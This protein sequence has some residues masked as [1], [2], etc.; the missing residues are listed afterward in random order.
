MFPPH[1]IKVFGFIITKDN[2]LAN[3]NQL[4]PN[5]YPGIHKDIYLYLT[6]LSM[7]KSLFQK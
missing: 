1:A 5:K 7:F 3:C 2:T 6:I 4:L